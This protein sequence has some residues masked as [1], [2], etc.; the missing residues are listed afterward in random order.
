MKMKLD[1]DEWIQQHI[2]FLDYFD[3]PGILFLKK[4]LKE[5]DVFI[6]AGANVGSYT[7]VAAK[8]VGQTGKVFAFEPVKKIFCRLKEAIALN[9]RHNI[10][11]EQKA[12]SDENTELALYLAKKSNLGMSSIY[13]H[14]TENGRVEKVEAVSLDDYLENH[15]TERIDLIK[16][17]V[18]GS[19]FSALKG[20]QKSIRKFKPK[21]LIELK[22]ET[23]S[24]SGHTENDID[25][26]LSEAGYHKFIID[27]QGN[28]TNNIQKKQK[29]YYNYI[30]VPVT[31]D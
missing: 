15:S 24:Q 14:D 28:I 29:D 2:F 8:Q 5:G 7:L 17:D 19:E 3:Y 4:N 27:E 26:L 21:I 30:F 13:H 1:L 18:E 9:N 25:D 10:F 20:M 6:D 11:A 16:I 22:K 12:L 31:T 23:L